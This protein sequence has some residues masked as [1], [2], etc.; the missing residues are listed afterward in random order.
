MGELKNG[1]SK[2][3]RRIFLIVV[4]A[5]GNTLRKSSKVAVA[6]VAL[7]V[8]RPFRQFH[9]V[10]RWVDEAQI[11]N[12]LAANENLPSIDAVLAVATKDLRSA[13][14][15]ISAC[16]KNSSNPVRRVLVIVNDSDIQI[17]ESLLSDEKVKVTSEGDFLP[18]ELLTLI[19]E[20][21]P[22]DRKGWVTQQVIGIFA[23][24]NSDAAG[25]LV[26]DAD[27]VFLR[28]ITFLNDH[29]IQLLQFSHEYVTQYEDHATRVWGK[30]I[31]HMKLS[32]VTHYQLMQPEIIRAMFPSVEHLKK[33]VWLGDMSLK[34]PIADYHSY[35]R[36]LADHF[37]A[38]LM[39]GRWGNKSVRWV[40]SFGQDPTQLTS[41]LRK[42]Y[43]DSY[44]VSFHT[45]L[46]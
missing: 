8:S 16:L 25:V 22:V 46:N 1:F 40:K 41:S 33:W 42:L 7:A 27:T 17:A 34:S 2:L 23:A 32:Y 37:P 18:D 28:P 26:L 15:A 10:R 35:G 38:R 30:R 12:P 19:E 11:N 3:R 44:S 20:N 24:L 4:N 36:Y 39:L 13:S 43:P 9:L 31:R 5:V 14:L 29:G 6:R 45:Y 21:H